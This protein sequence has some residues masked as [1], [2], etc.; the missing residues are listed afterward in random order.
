MSKSALAVSRYK[1]RTTGLFHR[2]KSM[3]TVE[4]NMVGLTSTV[5]RKL[6][7]EGSF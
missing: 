6:P 1:P 4:N 5:M 2:I 3:R 7:Q